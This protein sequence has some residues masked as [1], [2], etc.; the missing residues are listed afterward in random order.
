MPL[1]EE[2]SKLT[3]AQKKS[4]HL[5]ESPSL[6]KLLAHLDNV[7]PHLQGLKDQTMPDTAFNNW[8]TPLIAL[9]KES[10][11]NDPKPWRFVFDAPYSEGKYI[12]DP[13]VQICS[14]SPDYHRFVMTFSKDKIDVKFDATCVTASP[15]L[16]AITCQN[17]QKT[18]ARR[19]EED[20]ETAIQRI[21]ILGAARMFIH[22]L[23]PSPK[24]LELV[25]FVQGQIN[26]F[27][28]VFQHAD[29]KRASH[30]PLNRF[31]TVNGGWA[32][33]M[34]G[35]TGL[36]LMSQFAGIMAEKDDNTLAK[37]PVT[38]MPAGGAY[39]RVEGTEP[40]N[41]FEV[42]GSWG[43]DSK[44][45]IGYATSAIAFAPYGFW[46]EIELRNAIAQ[47]KPTVVITEK[48]KLD[49]LKLPEKFKKGLKQ[50]SDGNTTYL[51]IPVDLPDNKTGTYRLYTDAKYAAIWINRCW[52]VKFLENFLAT[53]D[54][55][56]TL[57]TKLM[58]LKN[59]YLNQPKPINFDRLINEAYKLIPKKHKAAFSDALTKQHAWRFLNELIQDLTR[60]IDTRNKNPD[61]YY[62]FGLFKF[63]PYSFSKK[64]KIDAANAL[65]QFLK[66]ETS[67]LPE[68]HK[69]P[70]EHGHL[71]RVIKAWEER[72]KMK[73]ANLD[74]SLLTGQY[75]SKRQ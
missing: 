56:K 6:K 54:L 23:N 41:Y 69:K 27:L 4:E 33:R 66:G 14:G 16:E 50:L 40:F 65:I 18:L 63:F 26:R 37:R 46:T 17:N 25:A 60:Y 12:N 42:P 39:D 21:A 32:G 73:L 51:E 5:L 24:H 48:N 75:N 57:S 34:E 49:E 68:E 44:Y 3:K 8:G 19:R 43:D 28:D 67:L 1:F 29:P 15:N 20:E 22:T 9:E 59:Q 38:I 35:S 62:F 36:P 72:S 10:S 31:R 64:Q 74:I 53:P 70:L 45:L 61:N 30:E 2:L 58:T 71:N 13:V 47:G 7:A 55:N 52:N 11:T